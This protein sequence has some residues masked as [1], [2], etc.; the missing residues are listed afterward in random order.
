MLI[1]A[2]V[3]FVFAVSLF[4]KAHIIKSAFIDVMP[5]AMQYPVLLCNTCVRTE[6]LAKIICSVITLAVLQAVQAVE[7]VVPL[8]VLRRKLPPAVSQRQRL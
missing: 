8:R 2:V 6:R 3:E 5:A 1:R 7:A 4:S